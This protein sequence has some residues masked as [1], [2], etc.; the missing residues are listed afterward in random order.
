MQIESNCI[1]LV[2]EGEDACAFVNFEKKI[3]ILYIYIYFGKL[4]KIKYISYSTLM[5]STK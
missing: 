5:K 3:Y 4:T 1:Y 2:A